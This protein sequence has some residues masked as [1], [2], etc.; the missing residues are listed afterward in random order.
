MSDLTEHRM[1]ICI[2]EALAEDGIS[3]ADFCRRVGISPKHLSQ[4]LNGKATARPASLDYWAHALDRR[5]VV[6]LERRPDTPEAIRDWAHAQNL[7]EMER[8]NRPETGDQS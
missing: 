4:V 7:K 8:L 1:A 3:Q 5:F 2:G 6:G